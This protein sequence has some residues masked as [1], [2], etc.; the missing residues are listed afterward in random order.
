MERRVVRYAWTLSLQ[1]ILTIVFFMLAGLIISPNCLQFSLWSLNGARRRSLVACR[2]FT[3]SETYLLSETCNA[4]V[5]PPRSWLYSVLGLVNSPIRRKGGTGRKGYFL[6]DAGGVSERFVAPYDDG[7]EGEW[8]GRI[9][10]SAI[11]G[12][13]LNE[14][15]HSLVTS[16]LIDENV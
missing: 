1:Q 16:R 8:V 10:E 13:L 9:S 14:S 6:P 15:I 2:V 3:S 11:L 12:K 7:V 4:A 5:F